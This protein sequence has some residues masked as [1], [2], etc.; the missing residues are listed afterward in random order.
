MKDDFDFYFTHTDNDNDQVAIK[1]SCEILNYMYCTK[2]KRLNLTITPTNK[3]SLQEKRPLNNTESDD[4]SSVVSLAESFQS[5][6]KQFEAGIFNLQAT[7]EKNAAT[8][9]TST[10]DTVVKAAAETAAQV[11][12]SMLPP[13]TLSDKPQFDVICD[14]CYTPIR[15]LVIAMFI[16][17]SCLF[18]HILS[19]FL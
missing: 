2:N 13:A 15:G 1:E 7:V 9:A 11:Y 16:F 10:V 19:F 5:I 18:I 17:C 6:M 14:G 12:R 4:T 3:K 8:V